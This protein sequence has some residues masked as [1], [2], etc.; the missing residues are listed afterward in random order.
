[1]VLAA[2]EKEEQG[3]EEHH[4]FAQRGGEERKS[5][6]DEG[7]DLDV[8]P[9]LAAVGRQYALQVAHGG[10]GWGE[11]LQLVAQRFDDV[12]AAPQPFDQRRGG[13]DDDE[14]D[15]ADERQH[16]GE[17][18]Q[19]GGHA[20]ALGCYLQRA[21]HEGEDQRGDQ[22]QKQRAGEIERAGEK[23]QENADR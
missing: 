21:E 23:Q 19:P 14:V 15:D 5:R 1:Q 8:H 20:P 16:A 13:Q 7:R 11:N 17:R 3:G 22:G 18:K 9:D 12:R 2:D 6:R 10:K 4:Q